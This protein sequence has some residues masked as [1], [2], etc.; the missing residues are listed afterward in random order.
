MLR[1]V[2][3]AILLFHGLI[4]LLGFVKAFK[5]AEVSQLMLPISKTGGVFWMLSFLLL[6]TAAAF[7]VGKNNWWWLFAIT[8]VVLSQ[9]LIIGAWQD[10]KFGTI[11]NLI[12]LLVAIEA[13][14]VWRFDEMVKAEVRQL[15]QASTPTNNEVI[16]P[17][18]ITRLP[19]PVQRWLNQ[20]GVVGKERSTS[21]RLKQKVE[22]KMKPEQTDWV[23]AEAQQYFALN[24]PSFVWQVSMQMMRGVEVVGRDKFMDGKGQMLIKA[25]GLVSI[26]NAADEKIDQGTLQ[27]YLAETVWFPSAA[28]SPY[29]TWEAIDSISAKATMSYKGTTGSGIFYFDQQ[30]Q[31]DKFITQRYMGSGA[32]AVL[33]EWVITTLETR[34][35]NGI[36][37][38]VKMEVTWK[39]DEG[40][41]NWLK[42]DITDIEYNNPQLY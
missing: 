24:E 35:L 26:V 16:T 27:R 33:R 11:A 19:V 28:L 25:F 23:K 17:D 37:I 12:I 34:N 36:N 39:L 29:I 31:F 3:I 41:F 10:A 32:E 18:K 6:L 15:F 20:S 1:F 2:F 21:V 8:G 9:V 4:H 7:F 13:F 42:L 5:L 14:A 22:M 38:P 40:D 30:G